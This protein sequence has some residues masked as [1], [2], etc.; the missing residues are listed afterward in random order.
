M[1]LKAPTFTKISR[2]FSALA[3]FVTAHKLADHCRLNHLSWRWRLRLLDCSSGSGSNSS[4]SNGSMVS[5]DRHNSYTLA[6]KVNALSV[7]WLVDD[8]ML[9]VLVAG[10]QEPGE[11]N[12][13]DFGLQLPA[14]ILQALCQAGI[15]QCCQQLFDGVTPFTLD[16]LAV[17]HNAAEE[18]CEDTKARADGQKL[19]VFELT[20]TNSTQ[21]L[22]STL[23]LP[24]TDTKPALYRTLHS[25]LKDIVSEIKASRNESDSSAT[26]R[27]PNSAK[28][29]AGFVAVLPNRLKVQLPVPP[30]QAH[31]LKQLEYG[32]LILL[33]Q[34]AKR[35]FPT[36][37]LHLP[38]QH[39]P[40]RPSPLE[41]RF[42]LERRDA[43]FVVTGTAKRCYP[44][45]AEATNT[46]PSDPL[47]PKTEP[48]ASAKPMQ[49]YLTDPD[50][51][52]QDFNEDNFSEQEDIDNVDE[53]TGSGDDSAQLQNAIDKL[54]VTL[55]LEVGEVLLTTEE[56]AEIKP[57]YFFELNRDINAPVTLK[58]NGIPVGRCELVEI[59]G[60]LAARIVDIFDLDS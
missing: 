55:T 31:A 8:A 38:S 14:P 4:G 7:H 1:E 49:Q 13:T 10:G 39:F 58:A 52:E 17:H 32:D 34:S 16:V 15:A 47:P 20:L 60:Q 51:M 37:Y 45:S 26:T 44:K 30:L 27:L 56:I 33:G 35:D 48:S 19:P 59:E 18:S 25:T 53:P 29:Q 12:F 2:E 3:N 6:L 21:R 36:C 28:T 11:T 40:S 50:T 23:Q 41:H 9:S 54:P 43:G 22:I 57:G 24:L 5:P 42:K 46:N